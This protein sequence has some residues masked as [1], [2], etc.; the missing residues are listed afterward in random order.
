MNAA[1]QEVELLATSEHTTRR[2]AGHSMMV[3]LNPL[4]GV[5][6]ASFYSQPLELCSSDLASLVHI[7][8]LVFS[9]R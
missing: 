8:W 4:L 2:V 6:V 9:N 7:L 5:M 1:G 3:D